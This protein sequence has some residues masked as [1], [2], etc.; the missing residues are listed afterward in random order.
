MRIRIQTANVNLSAD[1]ENIVLYITNR[2]K[3]ILEIS[4]PNHDVYRFMCHIPTPKEK[5]KF[6]ETCTR[7]MDAMDSK[8]ETF[9]CSLLDFNIKFEKSGR[10]SYLE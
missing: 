4:C 5:S 6:T 10:C 2:D 9:F 1:V 8:R 3:A 7:I